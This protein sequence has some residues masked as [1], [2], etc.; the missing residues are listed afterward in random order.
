MHERLMEEAEALVRSSV[1]R[2]SAERLRG[3]VQILHWT[4]VR[5]A[6]ENAMDQ[7]RAEVSRMQSEAPE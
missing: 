3:Q 5:Q 4:S 1:R 6:F 7:L 2:V